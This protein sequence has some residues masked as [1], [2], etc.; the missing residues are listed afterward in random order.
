[1]NSVDTKTNKQS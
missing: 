1:M